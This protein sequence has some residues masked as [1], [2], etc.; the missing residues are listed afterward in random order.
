MPS[1]E[2]FDEDGYLQLYPDIARGVASGAIESGWGHFSQSGFAE[3]REWLARNDSLRSVLREISPQDE[4]FTGNEAHY[5]DVGASALQCIEAALLTSRRPRCTIKR[6]LDLP[7]G[8]GRVLRYL[9]L[10]FPAA[11]LV[12]CDLNR[13]GV[14]FCA[15][16][17]RATPEYSH[18]EVDLIPHE[19]EVDLIWCGS[20][21]T[22]LPEQ[23]CRDFLRFFHRIL[24]HRGILVCTLHGRFCARELVAGNN[25]HR[26]AEHQ[27]E[28]LLA[29]FTERGFS[30]VD[31]SG[32]NGYGF[33]LVHPAFAIREFV[34]EKKWRL[35][36]LHEHGW[37]RRQD[38]LAIQKSVPG[39]AVGL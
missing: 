5:F 13:D 29:G 11:D 33:S 19:G 4:M 38:V 22:H 26:L 34:D 1:R 14:D 17:F 37:D 8:H 24:G 12:A 21:L 10:A 36:G 15:R 16:T 7:C 35:L 9:R 25:R 32:E 39:D 20:L 23:K 28:R 31:Y 3:G 18:P 6:I 27:V 2:E 30:Y